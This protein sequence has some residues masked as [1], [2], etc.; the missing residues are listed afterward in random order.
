LLSWRDPLQFLPGEGP[1][2]LAASGIRL[3]DYPENPDKI[4]QNVR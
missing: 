1:S 3:T 4:I 2:G